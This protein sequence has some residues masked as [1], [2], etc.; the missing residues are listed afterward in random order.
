MSDGWKESLQEFFEQRGRA[1]GASAPTLENLCYV[2]GRDPR[3]WAQ[4]GIYEDII[5][6]IVAS[7]GATPESRVLEVGCASGFI[8][9]GVAPRVGGYTG[10]DIAGEAL[11]A[12][13]QLGLSNA[14]FVLSDGGAL[15]FEDGVFDGALCYDVFTNLPSPQDGAAIIDQMLRVVKPGGKVLIGSIPDEA[16]RLGFEARV[17]AFSAE[18]EAQFGPPRLGPPPAPP[19]G[20]GERPNPLIVGYYF[21]RESFVALGETLGARCEIQEIHRMNPYYGFRFNAVY[22]RS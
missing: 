19:E 2:S 5:D 16:V 11:K 17:A 1:V 8:A 6:H 22:T 12:A 14:E 10:V 13:S 4:T 21:S 7:I 18:L 15:P 3:L 20:G 9:R